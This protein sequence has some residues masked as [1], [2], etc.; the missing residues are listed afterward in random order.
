MGRE[1]KVLI[2]DDEFITRQG[3]RHM[4]MWEQ[5]GFS[6]VGEASN[7]QE[8]IEMIEKYQPDIVLADIVMPVLNGIDFSMI[9][10]EKYPH[11]KLI[12]LSSYD[13]F[14]Y[15]RTTLLNGAV[16]YVLKPA[17]NPELLLHSLRKAAGSIPGF[18]LDRRESVALETQI[19]RVLTGY[20]ETIS[21]EEWKERLPHTHCC[22]LAFNMKKACGNNTRQCEKVQE[23]M[24]DMLHK[25][26]FEELC[27]MQLEQEIFCCILNYRKKDEELLVSTVEEGAKR[28]G[29]VA[30]NLLFVLS[31]GFTDIS[32]V[33][34]V[35][36]K[37]VKPGLEQK[38]Y[39]ADKFLI[40]E[41]EYS[42]SEVERFHYEEY[43]GFLKAHQF[44]Q[45]LKLLKEYM[46]Y[47]CASRYDEYQSKNLFKNL[48]YN[49]LIEIEKCGAKCEGLR[50]IYFKKTDKTISAEEFLAC[51]TEVTEELAAMTSE[52]VQN[53]DQRMAEIKEYI[54]EHY[55]EKLDLTDIAREF[56]FNYHYI[57]SYFNQHISEGFSGYLN[58]VRIEKSCELLR[59]SSMP[60]SNVS[61]SVGYSDHGYYCR[62]FKKL[63]GQTPSQYRR[64]NRMEGQH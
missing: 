59:E 31:N 37:A 48:L 54:K 14:E 47:L 1:C 2:V 27:A 11:I 17:L 15:V 8:G 18:S 38:F 62:M 30:E 41:G 6:I 49:M 50:E 10:Q 45:A 61:V 56:S 33:R 20:Q 21:K 3:I 36:E 46:E 64:K 22:I 57:S 28:S 32:G 23:I 13:N 40:F 35:Y 26:G 52:T 60:I 63:K 55:S 58:M 19:E 34:K 29:R 25:K 51:C 5:E 53:E 43:A 9:L 4:I 42:A 7:G 16:D 44:S 12:I 24:L 39:F